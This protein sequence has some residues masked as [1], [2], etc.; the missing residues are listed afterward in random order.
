MADERRPFV[1]EEGRAS[2]EKSKP[3]RHF[4]MY[5]VIVSGPFNLMVGRNER[6]ELTGD[7]AVVSLRGEQKGFVGQQPGEL[8]YGKAMLTGLRQRGGTKS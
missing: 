3:K 5:D 7:F 4:V 1:F 2:S 8:E 6:G